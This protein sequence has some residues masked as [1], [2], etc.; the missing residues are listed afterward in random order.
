MYHRGMRRLV[1]VAVGLGCACTKPNPD[2][3]DETTPCAVGVCDLGAHTCGTPV[4][5]GGDAPAD[6]PSFDAGPSACAL[7]GGQIVF[8]TDRDGDFEIARMYADGGGF[9]QL[10]QNTWNDQDPTLSPD[11][12]KISW[13]SNAS[14]QL[15][16]WVMNVDGT[17]P[18]N[19]S[20]GRAAVPRWSPDSA[21]LL[22]SRANELFTVGSDGAGLANITNTSGTR[23]NEGDWSPDGTRIVFWHGSLT[24]GYSDIL[25]AMDAD[26]GNET[27]IEIGGGGYFYVHPRWSPD[28]TKI[29]VYRASLSVTELYGRSLSG[30]GGTMVIG[31]TAD[32]EWSPSS[33]RVAYAQ[34]GDVFTVAAAGGT[35]TNLTTSAG[36]NDARPVWSP[37]GDR[38]AYETDIDGNIEIYRMAINGAS[39]TNLTVDPGEDHL[40]S[41][42]PCPAP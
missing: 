28:A 42:A 35:G 8:S 7:A 5:A 32:Q 27:S 25:Y 20:A 14:G 40:G 36:A 22:F 33:T 3:C 29:A 12:T 41:W 23:E 6:G 9:V 24:I 4:D 1:L 37:E 30:G 17:D 21:T 16:L 13:L 15:E 39:K 11:G 31:V 10:T 19:V 38:I 2:Y 18:H 26:G 34:S